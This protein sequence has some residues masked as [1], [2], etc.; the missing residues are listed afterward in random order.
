MSK[1]IKIIVLFGLFTF[2]ACSS[3][4]DLSRETYQKGFLRGDYIE[5]QNTA[6]LE[7]TAES[8]ADTYLPT[9]SAIFNRLIKERVPNLPFLSSVSL[10]HRSF[11]LPLTKKV[12]EEST[13]KP[14][15]GITS[16]RFVLQTHLQL[17]EV[18]E[19]ATQV[20]IYGRLWDMEQGDILWEGVGESRGYLFLFAPT[21]PASFEKAMEVA[22]RGLIRKLPIEENE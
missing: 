15:L 1:T 7:M 2:S 18:A 12:L 20:A 17:A 14:I 8:S 4:S 13:F 21:V 3:I 10:P 11:T 19:G 22:S 9:A 16:V 5:K 6:I